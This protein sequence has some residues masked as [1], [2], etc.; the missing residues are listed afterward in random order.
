M[1]E[2]P[3]GSRTV[4]EAQT[5]KGPKNTL[6]IYIAPLGI[7]H[8]IIGLCP[9]LCPLSGIKVFYMLIQVINYQSAKFHLNPFICFCDIEKQTFIFIILLVILGLLLLK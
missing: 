1:K 4:S 9:R 2:N 5:F 6:N 8:F 7:R 3:V